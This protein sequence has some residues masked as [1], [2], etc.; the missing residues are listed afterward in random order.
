M[1]LGKEG[2]SPHGRHGAGVRADVMLSLNGPAI[3]ALWMAGRG[4]RL[5]KRWQEAARPL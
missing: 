3:G 1:R 4:S 2:M 5:G